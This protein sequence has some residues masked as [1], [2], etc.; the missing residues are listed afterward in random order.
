MILIYWNFRCETCFKTFFAQHKL[1]IH[2]R[3]HLGGEKRYKCEHCDKAFNYYTD[4][5]RHT[6]MAH[7][8][9]RPYVC[10]SNDLMKYFLLNSEIVRY[11]L[12]I[13]EKI[14]YFQSTSCI[15][16]KKVLR[17]GVFNTFSQSSTS[18]YK[19][20][21]RLYFLLFNRLFWQTV[22]KQSLNPGK[23]KFSRTLKFLIFL[24][25]GLWQRICKAKFPSITRKNSSQTNECPLGR[26][27]IIE[28]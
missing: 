4:R 21:F 18:F 16:K 14:G 6:M 13:S 25:T 11:F 27:L 8:G 24:L 15:I 20:Y 12:L 19:T 9:E 26:G 10:V 28:P 5:K 23:F 7:T 2:L 17:F 3:L 1:K 22:L